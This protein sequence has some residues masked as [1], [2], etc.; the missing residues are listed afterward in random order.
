MTFSTLKDVVLFL[1][2]IY[3]AVLS[4]FNWRQSVRR[5]RRTV[6]VSLSTAL[7]AYNDGRLGQAFARL[8]ATNH[9][10]RT[11]TITTLTIELPTGGRLFPTTASE[12]PGMSD[13][14]LPAP[15][16]DGQSAHLFLSYRDI[17][18]A[19]IQSGRTEKVTLV[20]VCEDSVGGIYEGEPWEVD[21]GE[22]SRM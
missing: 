9:G 21:P 10:H 2:A 7:P 18:A 17:A 13:T 14:P 3:G 19:L 5:D 11:V 16:S 12:F 4:T 15:L 22:F 20:P 1:L 8:Q 6:T